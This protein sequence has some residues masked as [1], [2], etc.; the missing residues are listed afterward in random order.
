MLRGSASPRR[1]RPFRRRLRRRRSRLP[2]LPEGCR[3]RRGSFTPGAWRQEAAGVGLE[4]RLEGVGFQHAV[5]GLLRGLANQR[6]HAGEPACARWRAWPTAN[7]F[8]RIARLSALAAPVRRW[9]EVPQPSSAWAAAAPPPTW[10]RTRRFG[11]ATLGAS[12][13]CMQ[14]NFTC[15][16]WCYCTRA[17]V[18][19]AFSMMCRF[20]VIL[21]W[22]WIT[23]LTWVRQHAHHRQDLH[24]R[25]RVVPQSRRIAQ[26]QSRHRG[27]NAHSLPGS[28]LRLEVIHAV[29]CGQHG[30]RLDHRAATGVRHAAVRLHHGQAHLRGNTGGGTQVPPSPLLSVDDAGGLTIW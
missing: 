26:L 18:G 2:Q 13:R 5:G 8:R 20:L 21:V 24:A 14:N 30:V 28:Q 3:E 9:A 27:L 22:K 16:W 25:L 29:G 6:V 15:N 23:V 17:G 1:K 4:Q 10:R 12:E 7:G 11:N 19:H